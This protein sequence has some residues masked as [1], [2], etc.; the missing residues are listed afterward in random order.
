M[1]CSVEI[2]SGAMTN[3]QSFIK[4]GSG[5]KKFIGEDSQKH[6]IEIT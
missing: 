2:G 3:I 1:K 5:I 4:I 6:S